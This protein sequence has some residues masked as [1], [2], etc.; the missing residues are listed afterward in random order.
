MPPLIVNGTQNTQTPFLNINGGTLVTPKEPSFFSK[1]VS[2]VKDY[3]VEGYNQSKSVLDTITTQNPITTVENAGKGIYSAFEQPIKG[4]AQKIAEGLAQIAPN[5]NPLNP[6]G[7]INLTNPN[8]VAGVA[9]MISGLAESSLSPITGGFHIASQIPGI[10]QVADAVNLPF[11]LTGLGGSWASGKAIDWIPSSIV[12]DESKKIIKQPLQD[13]SS[14]AAQTVLGG[15]IMDKIGDYTS[16]GE[17]ITPETATKIVEESKLE[18]QSHHAFQSEGLIPPKLEINA[19]QVP[20]EVTPQKSLFETS[21]AVQT[22]L[23]ESNIQENKSVESPMKIARVSKA[24]SDINTTLV[25]KGFDA[26]KPETLATYDPIT[27]TDQIQRVSDLM[28]RDIQK[29]QDMAIG[30]KSVEA[31]V[32]PQVLFN[33]IEADALKNNDVALM[34]K[35]AKSPLATQLSEA[36]QTLGAHGFND[37]PNSPVRIIQ[38]VIKAREVKAQP[39]ARRALVDEITGEI[40]KSAPTKQTWSEFVDQIK[41]NY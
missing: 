6:A 9:K 7:V 25:E 19:P 12:S 10:R 3:A 38:D 21:N 35:L 34:Q 40:R 14:L 8:T 15:K 41:C 29:A 39:R 2:A 27:K 11:T 4:G 22:P 37:N 24:S 17:T 31:G 30:R 26:M 23:V 36:G 5:L 18:T 20:Q 16:R 33:A 32:H 28:T 1:A 13:L